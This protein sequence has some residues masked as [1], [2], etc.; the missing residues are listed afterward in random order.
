MRR[1][2]K[3]NNNSQ[4]RSDA[5]SETGSRALVPA[6]IS[7]SVANT[8]YSI[9]PPQRGRAQHSLAVPRERV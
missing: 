6:G 4:P 9:E 2:R 7:L 5:R 8:R 3:N 1:V